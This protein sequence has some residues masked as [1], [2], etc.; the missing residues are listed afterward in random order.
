MMILIEHYEHDDPAK[1]R[2]LAEEMVAGPGPEK[3]R[4]WAKGWVLRSDSMGKP[5]AMQF[6]A[7]DN[8]PVDLAKMKGKVVLVDFWATT[9]SPC[10]AEL[11][12]LKAAYDKFHARGFEVIGI[13]CDTDQEQLEWFVEHKELRWPQYYDGKQSIENKFAQGF[14]I[15]GIP[16]LFL[17]DKNGNLR[18]DNVQADAAFEGQIARMLDE[19]N[20]P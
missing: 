10:V 7:L 15:D 19:T 20:A 11:P 16:H 8:R 1:A 12:Q 5:V 14:G 9:C 6:T 2:Q 13:S 4:L 17:V 3:I 18:A